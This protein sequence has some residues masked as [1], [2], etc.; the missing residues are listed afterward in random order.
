V[1][2]RN[3]HK[4]GADGTDLGPDLSQIG[5]KYDREKLLESIMQPSKNIEPKYVTWLVE[6]TEGK[7]VT[8]LLV[9]KDGNEIVLKDTQNKEVRIATGNIESTHQMQHSLMPD[10]LLR[11]WTPQQVADLLAYLAS[12]K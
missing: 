4:I 6:T 3:C 5:K 8:G 2:C 9:H 11:D 10:L 12:L 1:Q 7:L